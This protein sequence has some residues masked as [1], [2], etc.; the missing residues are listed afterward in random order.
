MRFFPRKDSELLPVVSNTMCTA[1]PSKCHWGC[2]DQCSAPPPNLSK[3]DPF[4]DVLSRYVSRRRLLGGAAAGAGVLVLGAGGITSTPRAS[5]AP[6]K[7]GFTPITLN[8]L[9]RVT[10]AH[11]YEANVLIRWGD[12]LFDAADVFHFTAF[13]VAQQR[14]AFGYNCDYVGYYPLNGNRGLL[15]VNHEYTNPELMFY[16]YDAANPTE[17]QVDLE[18]EAHGLTVVEV[19]RQGAAWGYT[20]GAPLNRRITGTTP[21]VLT[22]PAAGDPRLQTSDDPTGTTVLG[23]FNNCS[24]GS[25]PWGTVLTCEE[26]FNQ[27]F[28]NN[29]LVADAAVRAAHAR[30]GLTAG[31]SARKWENHYARFDLAQEPNEAFRFGWVI[32][33]DPYDPTFVPRRRTALGRFKH[34]AATTALAADGRVAVYMGDD[35]RF[36]Y[37][38][39]FVS[40]GVYN[41]HP[42]RRQDNFDLLDSGTLYVAK[43]NDDGSGEWLP[44]VFG[45]GPLTLANGFVS[46]ADVLIRARAAGDA[47]GATKMDRPEDIETNPVNGKVYAAMTNNTRRGIGTNPPVDAAN[48][49]V[50]NTHGHIIEIAPG[51]GDHGALT[52]QWDIFMLC[53]DPSS[54]P[55][56]Y[57]AGFDTSLV[58]PISS[59]DNITF[60]QRGN[61]WISTDGQ[62]N[63]FARN[64][65]V[66]VV[67]VEGEERGWCR[68]FL[69]GVPGGEAA[70][71]CF[72]DKDSALFV[73]IQHPGEDSTLAAPASHFPDGAEPRPSVVVATKSK[74]GRIGS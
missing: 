37:M 16:G 20:V 47:L 24:A 50:G 31:A 7:L 22:G 58:S 74:G 30:Y 69:S 27:Y 12:P 55:S 25:T 61:L 14:R 68:Q 52:F 72:D 23:M 46:Q 51:G 40:D 2:G 26:N 28:A 1:T 60:D 21:T 56:T 18:L 6:S 65:G 9:D 54:D 70:S 38:Y 41:S 67:P 53:G 8:S 4:Q 29:S 42:Q 11:G 57:F 66:Y 17:E 63:T 64:D 19:K 48:P 34:E 71:L 62:I 39:K 15:V 59:P 36:D 3:N 43:F 49:R 35:E 44:M 5:A 73:A 13:T 45:D 33:L 32:E 10:V